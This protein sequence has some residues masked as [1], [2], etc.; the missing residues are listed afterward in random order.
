MLQNIVSGAVHTPR[1]FIQRVAALRAFPA[2]PTRVPSSRNQVRGVVRQRLYGMFRGQFPA[3]SGIRKL[4]L[5]AVEASATN[6]A[7]LAARSTT[8]RR[9]AIKALRARLQRR[10]KRAITGFSAAIRGSK[11][12]RR[13]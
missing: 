5:L 4:R 3:T 1:K 12:R 6:L 8:L 11:A 2:G 7:R 9:S 10:N 13:F